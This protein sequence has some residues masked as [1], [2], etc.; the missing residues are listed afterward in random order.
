[1]AKPA[2]GD[3]QPLGFRHDMLGQQ[4]VH[5]HITGHEG[6]P[7]GQL[8]SALT[9]NSLLAQDRGA[10]RGLV[11]QLERQAGLDPPAGL[12]APTAKQIPR[13][14]PQVLGNQ[15]PEADEVAGDLVGQ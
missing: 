2:Q 15:K 14:Q 6:Q 4:A 10:Q 9:E 8:E 3:L 7:I 11:D 5:G 1:V 12:T 13:S